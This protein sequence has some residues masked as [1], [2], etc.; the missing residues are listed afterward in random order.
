MGI[1][2]VERF[3][4]KIAELPKEK[5]IEISIFT[6]IFEFD[7]VFIAKKI[8]KVSNFLNFKLNKTLKIFI[9]E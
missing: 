7:E 6:Q 5:E 2:S 3:L 8:S 1:Q 4:H 9:K